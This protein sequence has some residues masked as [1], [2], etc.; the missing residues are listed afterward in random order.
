[1]LTRPPSARRRRARGARRPRGSRGCGR[2]PRGT[3]LPCGRCTRVRG[4]RGT[5]TAR[6]EPRRGPVA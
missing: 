6:R 1:M 4:S 3:P 2:P 5:R